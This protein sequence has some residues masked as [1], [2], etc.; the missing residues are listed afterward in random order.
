MQ[1][2]HV[3]IGVYRIQDAC[4]INVLRQGKLDKDTV[5]LRILVVAPDQGNEVIFRE[6]T[7]EGLLLKELYPGLTPEDIQ[8]VS[9]PKLII[10]PDLKEIEL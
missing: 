3:L 4:F 6:V 9:E 1:A 5:D 2:V 8:S 7:P 10:S